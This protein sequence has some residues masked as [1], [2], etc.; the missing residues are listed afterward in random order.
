MRLGQNAAIFLLFFGIAMLDAI[1][2]SDWLRAG[3]W[4]ALGLAF[5]WG[6]I[7]PKG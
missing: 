6:D 4:F 1:R 5:L 7:K 2:S 3:L